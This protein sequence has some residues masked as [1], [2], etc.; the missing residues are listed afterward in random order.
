MKI[1]KR[2]EINAP[3]ARVWAAISDHEQFG[4]WFRCK[5]DQPF[6]EGEW[7]TGMM[8][9]PGSEHVKWEA[10][11]V[12]VEKEKCLA[13]TWPPYVENNAVD[14]A[15]EPWLDCTFELEETPTGTLLTI[16]ESGFERLS[17]AIRD[18]A[19]RGNE[20]GW[21]IQA[22]HITEYVTANP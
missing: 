7:S 16:T 6:T 21:D 12:R 10:K 4:E 18:D 17:E 14:L 11:V 1:T 3:I 2:I 9:Y 13:F 19:R 15:S 22:G 8:T 5:L 20:Q